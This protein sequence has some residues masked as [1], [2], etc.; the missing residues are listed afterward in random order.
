MKIHY[1]GQIDG[2]FG[3]GKFG[4]N[5][6]RQLAALG[7]EICGADS[8][9]VV[10][11]PIADHAL[12]P[13]TG[14]RAKVNVG[15][16]FF[17]SPLMPKAV[18]NAKRYDIVYCGS[19]WCVE[20]ARAAGITNAKLLMQG[21]DGA[22]FSPQ[23]PRQPD[24]TIRIFSGGKFEYRK[25]QDL[26]IAAFR[27]FLKTHPSAHLVCSWFNPWP[28][29]VRGTIERLGWQIAPQWYAQKQETIFS[30]LLQIHRI[31]PES[32]TILPPLSHEA[33]AREMANTDFG[34]FPNRCEGGTNLVLM[35][36]LS[37]G[38]PVAANKLTGHADV[39][40]WIDESIPATEDANG[41]AE[42]SIEG[43]V[44][45][46]NHLVGVTALLPAPVFSWAS[47]AQIIADDVKRLLV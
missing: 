12:N 6:T 2:P 5:I 15:V 29:L 33:L 7:H 35:E 31:P 41:W 14:A 21:V 10:V 38:R 26:V 44:G 42:Q 1:A 22:I 25:G 40:M 11:M 9:E 17:E 16:A 13:A 24:G 46:M 47:A 8:A 43:I 34:V 37:C 36:Y 30:L 32:F 45:A 18:E 4:L 20:R 27:E 3:W 39:A 23:L 19:T 28:Q